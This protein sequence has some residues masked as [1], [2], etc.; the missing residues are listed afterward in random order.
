[1]Q[2]KERLAT[3]RIFDKI[4]T[5]L[6]DPDDSGTDQ[7]LSI[8][9]CPFFPVGCTLLT[10]CRK[11]FSVRRLSAG[12]VLL[13]VVLVEAK[14]QATST[15]LDTLCNLLQHESVPGTIT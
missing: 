1:V 9:I 4:E 7:Q 14:K 6:A 5:W 2:G 13:L 10:S 15:I 8:V 12:I 3:E 11:W